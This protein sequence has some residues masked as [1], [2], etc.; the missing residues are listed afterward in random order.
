MV[1][2]FLG[3]CHRDPKY[4]EKPNEFYPEHFLNE[5][6]EIRQNIEGFFPFSTGKIIFIIYIELFNEVI[7]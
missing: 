7:F 5:Q 4:W 6:G 3:G 1:G 2:A